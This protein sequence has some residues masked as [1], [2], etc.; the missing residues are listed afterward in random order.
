[1]HIG[2]RIWS[3]ATFIGCLQFFLAP[4][5]TD[6]SSPNPSLRP[7]TTSHS[8]GCGAS[9]GCPDPNSMKPASDALKAAGVFMFVSAGNSGP[10]CNTVNTQPVT[11][12]IT[13]L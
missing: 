8:Y 11:E 13:N 5:K 9:L 10:R 2:R 3:Q 12:K 7:H 1:M 4:T 6:G